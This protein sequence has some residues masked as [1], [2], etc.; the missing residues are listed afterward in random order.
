MSSLLWLLVSEYVKN[1]IKVSSIF[2]NYYHTYYLAYGWLELWLSKVKYH[3]YGFQEDNTLTWMHCRTLWCSTSVS[4]VS[5]SP[6][7]AD[8]YDQ[9]NSC[10][11]L[12]A[13][14]WTEHTFMSLSSGDCFITPL[15][16]DAA[17]WFNPINYTTITSSIFIGSNPTLTNTGAWSWESY[18]IKIIDEWLTNDNE[19]TATLKSPLAYSYSTAMSGYASGFN[20]LI[21]ANPSGTTKEFCHENT[22]ATALLPMKYVSITS[23]AND[24]K[25][26]ISLNAIKNNELPSFLCYGAINP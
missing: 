12:Y 5:R 21:I 13:S 9:W 24:W 3:G 11:Q 7:I 19:L 17:L 6:V 23:I 15:Y 25:D 4:I 8:T 1:M 20:Y 26:S 16:Y 22:W 2:Q 10:T 18:T 14:W